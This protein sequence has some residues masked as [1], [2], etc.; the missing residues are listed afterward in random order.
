MQ[1]PASRVERG[2]DQQLL[3][4]QHTLLIAPEY[5]GSQQ[6]RC[7]GPRDS[8]VLVWLRTLQIWVCISLATGLGP[9]FASEYWF[10]FVL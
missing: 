2:S 4:N 1:E 6:G 5:I 10:S 8:V 3:S 9:C 7:Q